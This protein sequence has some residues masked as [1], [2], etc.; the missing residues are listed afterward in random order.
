MMAILSAGVVLFINS[1]L[2]FGD[3]AE[4]FCTVDNIVPDSI[5]LH[6]DSKPIKSVTNHTQLRASIRVNENLHHSR[7]SCKAQLK[8][9]L[10]I[11]SDSV[12][13]SV[14]GNDSVQLSL[15]LAGAI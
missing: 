8:G 1:S 14:K 6:R 15:I 13:V 7:F 2:I 10:M 11:S 12:E 3:E 4:A 9:G 5:T